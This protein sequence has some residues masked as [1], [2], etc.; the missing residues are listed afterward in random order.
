MADSERTRMRERE[1]MQR[2]AY[3]ILL[4][5]RLAF[6]ERQHTG[7]VVIKGSTRE[8]QINR[9]GR[10]LY[11]LDPIQFENTPLQDWLVFINDVRTHSGKH[12]H[13]GGI[14]IYVIEGKGY[15]VVDGERVDWEKGDL[16]LLPIKP[17]GVEHQH[18]NTEPDKPCFWVAFLYM[19]IMDY[20]A[21]ELQQLEERPP[22]RER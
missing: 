22:L 3:E 14:I 12:R 15:S 16:L 18:F 7:Q 11:Y 6:D 20:V 10:L 2:S 21:M 1:P 4:R 8:M 17:K 13:Q 19:P 5:Q 9:Q